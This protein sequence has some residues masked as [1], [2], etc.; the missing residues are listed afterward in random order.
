MN[1]SR[2][3]GPSRLALVAIPATAALLLAG[4]SGG[5][6]G[7]GGN[8][9]GDAA[10]PQSITLAIGSANPN[11]HQFQDVAKAYEAAHKGVSIKVENLPG[12]GYPQAIATRVQAGNA[13]DVFQVASGSGQADS[14]AP[15]A[16]AGLLLELSDPDIK[17]RLAKGE[18]ADFQYNG[19]V[20]GVPTA[21]AVNGVVWN[22]DLAKQV[23]LD[24][25]A[26]TSLD[27]IIAQCPDVAAKGVAVFGLAG[28]VPF[29]PGIASIELATSIVYGPTP[30]WNKQRADG[31]VK[32]A[33]SKEWKSTLDYLKKMFEAGCFQP[34]AEGAG[35]D[36]LTNG[37]SSGKIIGF[38][39]PSGAA[40]SIM[41]GAGGH[42][43]L[44]VLPFPAPK[45]VDPMMSVS[46][47]ISVA[48]SS[49]TKSPKLVADFLKFFTEK[50]GSKTMAD[51][52]GTLPVNATDTSDLL[53]QYAPVADILTSGNTRPF[54]S[55]TWPNPKVYD[56]LGSGATA[57]MTGQ[58][59]ADEV[60]KQM[61]SDWG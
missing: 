29:N 12:E 26:E 28:A 45:G 58:K 60:L 33:T 54:A 46:S 59:S 8:G 32:F 44:T 42:V 15:L 7:S 52:Q 51:G 35:F 24:V 25:T 23:G 21:T 3:F 14:I 17:D 39:A 37:A 4:C 41:D 9:G 34:G 50:E 38:F 57:V 5:G 10:E 48:G 55:V 56:D 2:P 43:T 6:S 30:D 19:K 1:Q 31:K 16:K 40:K 53:P 22:P 13:P 11:E 61:D 27:D 49:K 47:D 18:E 20:Y 36:A